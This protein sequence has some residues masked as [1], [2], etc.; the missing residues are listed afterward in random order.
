MAT[1]ES[2][3]EFNSF[4]D[5]VSPKSIF[6]KKFTP[7]FNTEPRTVPSTRMIGLLRNVFL[8]LV[9]SAED[10]GQRKKYSPRRGYDKGQLGLGL[11]ARF[12]AR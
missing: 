2:I 3:Y 10:V 5:Y 12:A 8:V 7:R 11:R 1:F 9:F 6:F 4:D